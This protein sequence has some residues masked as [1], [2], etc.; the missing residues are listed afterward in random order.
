MLV[1]DLQEF[2]AKFTE[3]DATGTRQGNAVSNAIIMVEKDGALHEI[4]RMEVHEHA[5]PI[6]GQ[7]TRHTA[8]RLVLKTQKPLSLWMPDKLKGDY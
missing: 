5:A 6:I 3:A 7:A 8:H 1:K 2:L 4:K